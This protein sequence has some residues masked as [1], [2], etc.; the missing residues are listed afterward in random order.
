MSSYASRRVPATERIHV[1]WPLTGERGP[2][3][4]VE[5]SRE[6]RAPASGDGGVARHARSGATMVTATRVRVREWL[7]VPPTCRAQV[8]HGCHDRS[9]C[10]ESRRHE[11]LARR[12]D[13]PRGRA[14]QAAARRAVHAGQ[15]MSQTNDTTLKTTSLMRSISGRR[16]RKRAPCDASCPADRRS[17]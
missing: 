4:G 1:A 17:P 12:A 9:G 3:S 13:R 2:G 14:Q 5:P 11:R 6:T 7:T 15:S 10:G 16:S 8:P